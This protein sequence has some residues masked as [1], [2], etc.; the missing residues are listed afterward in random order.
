[1][2]LCLFPYVNPFDEL[3]TCQGC[4]LLPLAFSPEGS[5]SA[6]ETPLRYKT[7][8]DEGMDGIIMLLDPKQE[9]F[10]CLHS[11]KG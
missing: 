11:Y 9:K 8:D 2:C 7:V 5:S 6:P 4:T 10:P 1:M 3:P